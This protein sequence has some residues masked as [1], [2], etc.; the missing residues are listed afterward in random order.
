MRVGPFSYVLKYFGVSLFGTKRA[1]VKS[2]TLQVLRHCL[3]VFLRYS[4]IIP[5]KSIATQIATIETKYKKKKVILG[6]SD[7][8]MEDTD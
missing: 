4:L 2:C 3:F 5:C 8:I 6:I 1:A 7:T